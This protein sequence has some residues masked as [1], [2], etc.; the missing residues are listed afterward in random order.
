LL[1][2]RRY[3]EGSGSLAQL[4]HELEKEQPTSVLLSSEDFE[5]LYRRPSGLFHLRN[6]LEATGYEVRIVITLR[7]PADYVESLYWELVTGFE[8]A[9]DLETFVTTALTEGS[10][11]FNEWD[12][13]FDYT[14]L[15]APFARVFG[16]RNLLA[17][18]YDPDDSV[19]PLLA[20]CAGSLGV[21]LSATPSWGRLNARP[22]D[23]TDTA[24]FAPLSAA[25]R[26]VL[27][28]TFART[29]EDAIAQYAQIP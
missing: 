6:V 26:G 29:T 7:N 15:L 25:Q 3:D 23:G 12:F 8:L 17:L 22:A 9:D 14:R 4:A 21:T 11:A 27:D 5:S 10:I 20:A 24:R 18:R 19:G 1:H 13:C 2:D 16:S 28:A